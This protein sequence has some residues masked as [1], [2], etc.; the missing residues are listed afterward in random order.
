MGQGR[1]NCRLQSTSRCRPR[2][3]FPTANS[4]ATA[5]WSAARARGLFTSGARM[6]LT[7]LFRRCRPWLAGL[8]MAVA[9]VVALAAPRVARAA[10]EPVP[11]KTG[12]YQT[13][14]TAA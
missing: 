11:D 4:K 9:L 6:I 8:A 1:A 5:E 10:D 7:E 12:A 2:Q 14:P 3:C 13:T